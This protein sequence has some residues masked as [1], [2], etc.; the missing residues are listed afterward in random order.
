MDYL[1]CCSKHSSCIPPVNSSLTV[2]EVIAGGNPAEMAE[3]ADSRVL[4]LK[5]KLEMHLMQ[6]WEEQHD[7]IRKKKEQHA[8]EVWTACVLHLGTHR[9]GV[10]HRKCHQ[11][12][13]T[14]TD[15]YH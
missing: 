9:L 13:Y 6:L 3:N 1:L 12:G 7:G 11:P 4:E 5:E 15:C 8:T 14:F 10:T 2:E